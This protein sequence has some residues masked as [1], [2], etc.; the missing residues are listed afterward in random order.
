VVAGQPVVNYVYDAAGRMTSISQK[1]GSTT[2]TYNLTYDAGSRRTSLKVPVSTKCKDV[3]TTYSPYDNANNILGMLIQG[4]SVQIENLVYQYDPNGNRTK[5]TRNATQPLRDTV[6]STT[7]DDANEMLSFTPATGSAKNMIYDNNGNL[8]TV[9]NSCGTTTYAWDA[10]NRL[11]GI[12]GYTSTCTALSAAFKYDA[13][14]RRIEKT[15]NGTTTKYLYD[16]LDI[17]QEIQGTAKTNY[18]RTLNI[19]EPLTRIRADG[20]VRHYVKDA[21]GSIIA[22]TDDTGAVKTTYAYDPFGKVTITGEASD[23][24]FQYTGRENDGTGLYYYRFRYYSPELQRFIS[25]DPIGLKAGDVNFYAFVGNNPV[26][27]VD[28]LGLYT[29]PGGDLYGKCMENAPKDCKQKY[30]NCIKKCKTDPCSY[31][32][33]KDPFNRH[34]EMVC[35]DD[36]IG[37]IAIRTAVSTYC[38]FRYFP[39]IG[40]PR[41]LK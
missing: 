22:L 20:T 15:I 21:L 26:N 2:R 13:I 24:P 12:S 19:D 41:S 9:I 40:G 29:F 6:T 39:N 34:C 8:L 11:V 5:F 25:E 28:P 30:D 38:R 32:R 31:D 16:G 27:F 18:I 23:N 14:G 33:S 35:T 17:I 7:Y 3:T 37:C 10:R 1:I 4:P 36:Y